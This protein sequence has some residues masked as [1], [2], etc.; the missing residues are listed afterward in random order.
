MNLRTR[1][2]TAVVLSFAMHGGAVAALMARG[3]EPVE[4]AGGATAIALVGDGTVDAVSAGAVSVMEP[5]SPTQPLDEAIQPV[6]NDIKPT[7]TAMLEPS[8]PTAVEPVQP[9]P[10]VDQTPISPVEAVDVLAAQAPAAPVK[11][12]ETLSAAELQASETVAA[13]DQVPLPTIRPVEPAEQAKPV[14][15]AALQ[16]KPE[17]ERHKPLKPTAAEP[18]REKPRAEQPRK[19]PAP[20]KAGSGGKSE[21]DARKGVATGRTNGEH[22]EEGDRRGKSS[23]EGNAATSNYPGKVVS[24]LRRSLRY[25]AEARRQKIRG[26]VHVAF[27]VAAGGGVSGVR[28]VRSSGSPVLDKAAVETVQRAAPFPPIPD[29]RAN[30]PFTVPLAFTR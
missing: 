8:E 16:P 21:A 9:E 15:Q 11:A 20:Q 29:G 13:L 19:K 17:V 3:E 23:R 2:L 5:I 25:P 6:S 12:V 22:A 7:V 26:E 28:V 1:T 14:Q 30:W 10:I 24:K 4:I 18:A 27:T